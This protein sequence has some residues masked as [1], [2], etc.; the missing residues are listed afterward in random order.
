M[1]FTDNMFNLFKICFSVEGAIEIIPI[2][3]FNVKKE[4]LWKG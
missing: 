2:F 1:K 4:E 3:V